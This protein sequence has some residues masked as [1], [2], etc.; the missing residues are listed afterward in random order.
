MEINF[1]L[2]ATIVHVSYG[3]LQLEISFIPWKVIKTLFI[4]WVLM[5]RLVIRFAQDHLIIQPKYGVQSQENKCVH[6]Q[7]ILD[8]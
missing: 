2:V 7:D 8:K 3:I 5:F 6:L 4:V 1:L